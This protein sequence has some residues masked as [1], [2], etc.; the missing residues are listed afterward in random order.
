V[1][2]RDELPVRDRL[3]HDQQRALY[4]LA[5]SYVM[6]ARALLSYAK[7]RSDRHEREA[8]ERRPRLR[9]VR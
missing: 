5:M 8:R 2:V 7:L 6:R 4:V 9:V 1:S 3:H